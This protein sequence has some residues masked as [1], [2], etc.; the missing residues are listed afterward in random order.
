MTKEIMEAKSL[1]ESCSYAELGD[2]TWDL[3][4]SENNF[5][6][7]MAKGIDEVYHLIETSREFDLVEKLLMAF[8]GENIVGLCEVIKKR[9]EAGTL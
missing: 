8:T 3:I 6:R 4:A 9:K 1:V 5:C 2:T 7:D